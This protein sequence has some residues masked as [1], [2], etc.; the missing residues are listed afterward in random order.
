MRAKWLFLFLLMLGF[1]ISPAVA[2]D[3]G[4]PDTLRFTPSVHTWTI[5]DASDTLF[6]LPLYGRTDQTNI[7]AVALPFIARTSTGGGIGHDDSL[8]AVDNFIFAV[9]AQ[10]QQFSQAA[11][12]AATFP[13]ALLHDRNGCIV[14]IINLFGSSFMPPNVPTKLGDLRLRALEP[15]QLP[16]SFEIEVDSAFFPPGGTFKFSPT[17]GSGFPPQFTKVTVTVN[18]LLGQP[19]A[20][21]IVL[22][23]TSFT[24]NAAQGGANPA[25]QLL[26]ITNGSSGTLD[27]D[28][29]DDA[30]W[31]LLNPISGMGD[32]ST[33]LSVNVTGLIAGTYNATVTVT[34]PGA[35]N[36]PQTAQVTLVVSEPPPLIQLDPMGFTFN[37][38]VGEPNPPSQILNIT[39]G[40]GMTLN[41]AA[42]DDA[43]WLTLVPVSG[44]GDGSTT[45]SVDI[46][47]LSAATY[48]ATVTVTDPLATNS[49]QTASVTLVLQEPPPVIVLNPT[50]FYFAA[51]HGGSNPPNQTLLIT[52]SGGRTLHW[53]ATDDADWLSIAPASGTGSGTPSLIVNV[54]GILLPGVYTATV[55]VTDPEAT[56]SPQMAAVTLDLAFPPP[57]P[58]HIV[59]DPTHFTF[60]A[61]LGDPN[62]PSQIL[63]ISNTGGEQLNWSASDNADWLNLSPASGTDDGAVTVSIDLSGIVSAGTYN[64]AITVSDPNA[65]NSPQIAGVT[66]V[67]TL[68]QPEY[69]A[70]VDPDPSFV[71]FKFA[72]NPIVATIYVGNF[73]GFTPYDVDPA[74][75]LINGSIAATSTSV[76]PSHPEFTG[77]V[78]AIEIP[79]AAF[80]D[81]YGIL[82]DT[83]LHSF[84]VE[85]TA[86]GSID[87]SALGEV[88][89]IGKR[90]QMPGIY[91]APDYDMSVPG[92]VNFSGA[93]DIDDVMMLVDY[94]FLGGRLLGKVSRGDMD[95]SHS[96]DIDDVMT[97]IGY[98]FLGG[99]PPCRT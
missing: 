23:P 57:P 84:A 11:L 44:S 6:L 72:I 86:L 70:F 61:V 47:G 65:D 77:E 79:I 32:G 93:I 62:P 8:I 55:T 38:V 14:G 78:L 48:T 95:C 28:A 1:S 67:V 20:P 39:N 4:I 59:L 76:V 18:N 52:N 64:A 34:D 98:V 53:S 81:G 2:Q 41:W 99:H 30:D 85:G 74:S 29:S 75:L 27:W 45:L 80:L 50:E 13:G 35:D 36:S 9:A 15:T 92:D 88:V 10:V 7:L 16:Q 26:S 91:F 73:V 63:T 25:N 51:V 43:N 56:N 42:S 90:S 37:A 40:G 66:L 46:T 83:T 58:A 69:V 3:A 17:G 60:S 89:L 31:L 49:P 87:F 22:D 19:E 12:D 82:F 71:Y 21:S 24:F 97:L 5:D 33:T 54:S 96:V 94:V 68:V